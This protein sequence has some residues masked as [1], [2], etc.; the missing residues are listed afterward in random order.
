[1][2]LDSARVV[3]RYRQVTL[4]WFGRAGYGATSQAKR[5]AWRRKEGLEAMCE[6]DLDDQ[7]REVLAVL[8]PVF[9]KGPR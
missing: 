8:D 9:S 1:M 5:A 4:R 3:A 2:L 6:P 7:M